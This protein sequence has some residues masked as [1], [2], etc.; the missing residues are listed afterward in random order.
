MVLGLRPATPCGDGAIWCLFNPALT[1]WTQQGSTLVGVG[2]DS[3]SNVR[4]PGSGSSSRGPPT[5]HTSESWGAARCGQRGLNGFSSEAAS[6]D[7]KREASSYLPGTV[8]GNTGLA[9][10]QGHAV[11]L[12]ADGTLLLSR[13]PGDQTRASAAIAWRL[14]GFRVR[15][16]GGVWT[17]QAQ[18]YGNEC[19]PWRRFGVSARLSLFAGPAMATQSLGV[20][21]VQLGAGAAWFTKEPT[22]LGPAWREAG[23]G[24]DRGLGCQY[25]GRPLH[26]R[27]AGTQRSWAVGRTTARVQ[28]PGPLW[29]FGSTPAPGCMVSAGRQAD[30]GKPSR[31]RVRL[32]SAWATPRRYPRLSTESSWAGMATANVG[33][34]I[35]RFSNLA[36][37]LGGAI[38]P[39]DRIVHRSEGVAVLRLPQFG[40][41]LKLARRQTASTSRSP[42]LP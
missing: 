8:R 42:V 23:G 15:R 2:A 29:R 11:A 37:F 34:A 24:S 4:A 26:C 16:G 33:R 25:Q 18:A 35:G 6:S 19:Q 31:C 36:H 40:Y 27:P 22:G 38:T 7:P 5:E 10:A 32:L 3:D 13:A 12:S 41:Q 1:L 30:W 9:A 20:C 28:H 14:H 17:Q 21:S 39:P